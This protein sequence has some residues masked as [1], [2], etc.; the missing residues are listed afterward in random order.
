MLKF[1]V[2]RQVLSILVLQEDPC[3]LNQEDLQ[4]QDLQKCLKNDDLKID[5]YLKFKS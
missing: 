4:Y 2:E 1:K 5:K 3:L